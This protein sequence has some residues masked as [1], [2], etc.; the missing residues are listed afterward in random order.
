MAIPEQVRNRR[1]YFSAEELPEDARTML[2]KMLT[3]QLQ[4]EYGDAPDRSGAVCPTVEDKTWLDLQLSQEKEHGLG[5]SLM[6]RSLGVDPTE[7]IKEAEASITAGARKLDYFRKRMEDWV[8]RTMTRVLAERTGAIQTVAGLGTWYVP[9]ALWHAKNY[10]DEALGH[11]VMGVAYAQR[12]M[13]EGRAQE[14]QQATDKFYPW[15][16]DI[17]GGVDTPNE[18]KYLDTGLKT[19]TNNQTRKL[20]IRSLQRDLLALGLRMPADAWQGDRQRYPEEAD[21]PVAVYLD[22]DE[23]PDAVKPWLVKLL[24]G[25]VQAKYA[26]QSDPIVFAA[27]TPEQKVE[28]GHQL[29]DERAFGLQLARLLRALGED[30]DAVAEEA[31]RTLE[32]GQWKLDFLKQPLSFDWTE[33]CVQQWLAARAG[34]IASLACFGSCLVPLGAWAGQHYIFQASVCEA[35]KARCAAIADRDA[36]Q[37]ALDQWYPY[38]VDVFG[39]DGT[40]NE[41]R[42]CEL[43]IKT[44]QNAH[45]RQIFV[46]FMA[47]EIADLGLRAPDLYQGARRRYQPF[48]R[49]ETAA[50]RVGAHL[51]V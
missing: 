5:V 29:R 10:K 1:F 14:C 2:A 4:S 12:L 49:P 51:Y 9:L 21:D 30:A 28:T 46:D 11:T 27:P 39:A 42:Y 24:L 3:V 22:V 6:L 13:D 34:A 23:V 25:W 26:R 15:C 37:T 38:A 31:E 33:C 18:R 45:L 40:D 8:E 7:Y 50:S 35:W 43:G 48:A 17:F 20:W 32:G 19:L 36:L 44:A 47:Q 16:L 41:A